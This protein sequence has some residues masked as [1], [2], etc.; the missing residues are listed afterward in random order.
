MSVSN[1][2]GSF[3]QITDFKKDTAVFDAAYFFEELLFSNQ[4]FVDS[5]RLKEIPHLINLIGFK[6]FEELIENDLIRFH[7]EVFTAAQI[8]QTTSVTKTTALPPL[9]YKLA[10]IK[11]R[12]Q[13]EY[14]DDHLQSALKLLSNELKPTEA[15][16]LNQKLSKLLVTYKPQTRQAIATYFEEKIQD[17]TL[18]KTYILE[19]LKKHNI[20]ETHLE[21]QIEWNQ[22]DKIL[23]I[24]FDGEITRSV[25]VVKLHKICEQPILKV[26]GV[27][28]SLFSMK[29]FDA[30]SGINDPSE[31]LYL[32]AMV[33]PILENVTDYSV[34]QGFSRIITLNNLPSFQKI[35]DDGQFNIRKFLKL[36]KE[37]SIQELGAVL[38]KIGSMPSEEIQSL[39][40]ESRNRFG[41][42][43]NS[44]TGK[45]IRIGVASAIG[46]T[47]VFGPMLGA[48]LGLLES[49]VLDRFTKEKEL[50]VF[51]DKRYR[52]FSKY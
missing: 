42:M 21:F 12:D 43:Y 51:I 26:F 30:I 50:S 46:L 2:Y 28:K 25:S 48:G 9:S 14:I 4:L 19:E 5:V 10:Y 15:T 35:I 49:F 29:E 23:T 34:H 6:G 8:G 45:S 32:D 33:Y 18:L 16:I 27:S 38:S 11:I 3:S 44:G 52:D 1:I 17:K 41:S 37:S 36:K 47:P 20:N 40:E 31:M 39:M 22:S 13:Y 24:K 7:C